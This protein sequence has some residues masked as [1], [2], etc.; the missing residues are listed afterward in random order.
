MWGML[1]N[2]FIDNNNSMG[3][4]DTVGRYRSGSAYVQVLACCFTAASLN[5]NQCRLL[6]QTDPYLFQWNVIRISK[7]VFWWIAFEST[8]CK[9]SASMAWTLTTYLHGCTIDKCMLNHLNLHIWNVNYAQAAAFIFDWRMDVVV[10]VSNF[11]TGNVL[12]RWVLEPL[13]LGTASAN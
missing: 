7:Y 12:T 2:G 11:E 13:T 8:V 6:F 1:C 3:P 4:S 10:I 9:I 5:G